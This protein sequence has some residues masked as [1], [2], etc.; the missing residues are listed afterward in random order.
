MHKFQIGKKL[1]LKLE[2][3]IE[4]NSFDPEDSGKIPLLKSPFN[5]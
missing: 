2:L 1:N 4:L 3:Q 5:L